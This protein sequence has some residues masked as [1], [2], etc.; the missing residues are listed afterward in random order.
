[1]DSISS[2]IPTS[3]KPP[4]YVYTLAY[5]ESMA[6]YIFYV[7]KGKG[8]RIYEHE[9]KARR[10]TT[11]NSHKTNIIRKVERNGERI[12]RTKLGFFENEV[13]A[14]LYETALIF[15]MRPYE[16]LTNLTDGGEGASGSTH[17]CPEDVKL[18]L[19]ALNKGK[20]GQIISEAGRQRISEARAIREQ[21]KVK[22]PKVEVPK[23]PRTGWHHSEATIQELRETAGHPKGLPL[24]ETHRLAIGKGNEGKVTSEGTKQKMREAALDRV[25]SEN[26][27]QKMS[28]AAKVNVQK[29]SRGPDGR[30]QS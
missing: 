28:D 21:T 23:R 29:R 19:S 3:K 30:F 20:P 8:N 15:F 13:D 26:A 24:S 7:G 17:V 16:H 5:P 25:M 18:K 4:Y 10:A 9:I 14:F 27:C 12:V 11:A 22:Q 1:M 2:S 6:G